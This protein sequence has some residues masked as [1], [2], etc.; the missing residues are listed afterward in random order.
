M[1]PDRNPRDHEYDPNALEL[2]SMFL[3]SEPAS[4][5][6]CGKAKEKHGPTTREQAL[7]ST[8]RVALL[9]LATLAAGC[10]AKTIYPDVGSDE[11]AAH[12]SPSPATHEMQCPGAEVVL[13]RFDHGRI[14]SPLGGEIDDHDAGC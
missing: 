14:C 4:C 1:N 12:C 5:R 10:R 2:P 7:A 9:A 11:P 13:V 3:R 6:V 8:A